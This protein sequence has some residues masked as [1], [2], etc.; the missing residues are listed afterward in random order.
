M[1]TAVKSDAAIELTGISADWGFQGDYPNFAN[2][3]I[4]VEFISF[5]PGAIGDKIS[6][7]HETDAGAS[8]FPPAVAPTTRAETVY[9]YGRQIKPYVDFSASVLSVGHSLIV[10][11]S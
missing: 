11:L 4:Q 1:T 5:T 3:G 8:I 7:K 6:I 2:Q 10:K 9:Y